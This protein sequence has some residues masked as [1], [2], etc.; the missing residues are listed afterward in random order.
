MLRGIFIKSVRTYFMLVLLGVDNDLASCL[1]AFT[2]FGCYFGRIRDTIYKVDHHIQ[3]QIILMMKT[4]DKIPT[5][6]MQGIRYQRYLCKE[7]VK[8]LFMIWKYTYKQTLV[9]LSPQLI[10]KL[11]NLLINKNLFSFLYSFGSP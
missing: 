10:N 4:V 11:I 2:K 5:L 3:I 1:E 7:F 6:F 8:N 9:F